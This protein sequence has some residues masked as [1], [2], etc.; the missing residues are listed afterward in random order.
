MSNYTPGTDFSV[1]DGLTTGDPEKIILGADIDDELDAINTAISSKEDTANKGASSGYAPLDGSSLVPAANLPTATSTAIGALETATTAEAQ[2]VTATDKII[3]PGNIASVFAV[4][5]A[6]GSS[7][8]AA[9]SGT[10][11]AASSALTLGGVGVVTTARTLTASTGITGGGD[12]S[13]N[14]SV[15]LDISGLT[16]MTVAPVGTDGFLIDDGGTM[17]RMSYNQVALPSSTDADAYSFAST[18]CGEILYYTGTG[19]HTWTMGTGVGQNNT[20]IIVVNSGSGS[21]TFAGSGVTMTSANSLLTLPAGGTAVLIR[22]SSTVWFVS[23]G[24]Q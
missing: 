10:T 14:R 17:K 3:T 7:T 6:L 11:I 9:V 18:D 5:P 15:A 19:G 24:L 1:K 22:E 12:L 2:A 4:P 20:F 16:G 8:P 21:I 23:G 13:A